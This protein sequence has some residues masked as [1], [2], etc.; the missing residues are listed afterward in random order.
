MT[1]IIFYGTLTY[2]WITYGQKTRPYNNQQKK[3]KKN[4]KIV[5]FVV[6]ADH[7]INLEELKRK[8]STMP[9]LEY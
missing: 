1:H 6:L 3:K 4:C 5:D 9:L 2:K 7:R 8:T